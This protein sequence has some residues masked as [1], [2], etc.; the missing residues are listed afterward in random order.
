MR[1]HDEKYRRAVRKLE[2]SEP[3]EIQ[4]D[5]YQ[6]RLLSGIAAATCTTRNV[7]AYSALGFAGFCA[8]HAV[9][10]RL[11]LRNDEQKLQR[12]IYV[13]GGIQLYCI[14]ASPATRDSKEHGPGVTFHIEGDIS[15]IFDRLLE[16]G[17]SKTREAAISRAIW[18]FHDVAAFLL[19][20]SWKLGVIQGTDFRPVEEF[21]LPASMSRRE[22]ADY[23][24]TNP[25]LEM[26]K[27]KEFDE[28]A[29]RF[30]L[31][32]CAVSAEEEIA[33]ANRYFPEHQNLFD[34]IVYLAKTLALTSRE[35]EQ[36]RS[37]MTTLT[38][39][40]SDAS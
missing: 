14:E 26:M 33:W 5:Q 6:D 18:L 4:A 23:L 38:R 20:A 27:T 16:R 31:S 13:G 15:Q 17:F 9:N 37:P 7:S 2:M 11:V 30:F 40:M 10:D 8:T 22:A 34:I 3:I 32:T 24:A 19:D 21:E 1:T 35:V 39:N 36:I 29:A 25:Q 28:R 12:D